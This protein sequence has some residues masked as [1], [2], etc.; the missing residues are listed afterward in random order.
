MKNFKTF[1]GIL[2]LL[3]QLLLILEQARCGT[4]R[5]L[6]DCATA[7]LCDCGSMEEVNKC[8]RL[9]PFKKHPYGPQVAKFGGRR[10]LS[11]AVTMVIINRM[12]C[13]AI[14]L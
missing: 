2:W 6:F 11:L 5:D 4:K 14:R 7:Q 8:L 13:Y 12:L 9:A 10:N 1:Q 3:C